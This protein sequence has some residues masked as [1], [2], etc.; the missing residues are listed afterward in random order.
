MKVLAGSVSAEA[1]P[2]FAG[3]HPLPVPSHGL[4]CVRGCV[5][6]SS[7]T[8]TPVRTHPDDLI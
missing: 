7:L 6:V 3:G 2:W 1:S 8:R 5:Q 4:L